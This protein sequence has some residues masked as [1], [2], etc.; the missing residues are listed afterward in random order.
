MIPIQEL[1]NRIKW[2]KHLNPKE[3]KIIYL[4]RI[5]NKGIEIDFSDIIDHSKTFMEVQTKIGRTEIPLHRVKMV[6][7]NGEIFWQREQIEVE[8]HNEEDLTEEKAASY[9][10]V[11]VQDIKPFEVVTPKGNQLK[12]WIVQSRTKKMGSLLIE[13]ANGKRTLQ[14]VTGMPKIHY[15][16]EMQWDLNSFENV[17]ILEKVDGTNIVFFPLII[18]GKVVEICSKTRLMPLTQDK[19][20][21]MIN[22]VLA[23]SPQILEAV[24]KERVSI[25]TEVFGHKNIHSVNYR[26]LGVELDMRVLAILDKGRA[27]TSQEVQILVG[28]YNLPYVSSVLGNEFRERYKN[29]LDEEEIFVELMASD[30]NELYLELERYFEKMNKKYLEN[31]PEGTVII[32]GAVWHMDRFGETY[33]LKNKA[34]TVKETHIKIAA[35]IP[36][37]FIHQ[38]LNKVYDNISNEEFM[39]KNKII[40]LVKEELKEEFLK[41]VVED[42]RVIRRMESMYD[43]FLDHQKGLD[44]FREVARNIDR[45]IGKNT[46]VSEKLR[47]FAELYPTLKKK[48]NIMFGIFSKQV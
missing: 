43:E 8:K 2:D 19:W 12:G 9:L 11:Q 27:L 22:E 34:T 20:F 23:K 18:D 5:L 17:R 7:R 29:F 26:A 21:P 6:K 10:N 46:D 13:T 35:G 36:S 48:S 33:M 39:D 16:D 41:E 44:Y 40:G 1:L 37:I 25:S 47:K 38:A 31:Y 28:R 24:E 42:S 32:E 15:N 14:Y 3:F 30:K 45:E 4:D